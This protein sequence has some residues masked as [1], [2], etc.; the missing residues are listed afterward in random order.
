MR[1]VAVILFNCKGFEEHVFDEKLWLKIYEVKY[2]LMSFL[3]LQPQK[4]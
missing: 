3:K 4:I 1:T 2:V